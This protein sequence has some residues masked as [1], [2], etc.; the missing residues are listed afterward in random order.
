MVL[1]CCS[2]RAYSPLSCST[3]S[4][5]PLPSCAMRC[6]RPWAGH[7]L[8]TSPI[9]G[10]FTEDFRPTYLIAGTRNSSCAST[11]LLRCAL[12][13]SGIEADLHAVEARLHA[14]KKIAQPPEP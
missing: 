4:R 5:R 8:L 12:H 7:N 9:Y 10:E 2:I 13:R 6:W 1:E 11:L 14:F 3:I